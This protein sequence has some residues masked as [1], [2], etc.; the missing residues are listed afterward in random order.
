MRFAA[1]TENMRIHLNALKTKALKRLP[2]SEWQETGNL[3]Y[4]NLKPI[5]APFSGADPQG[6]DC[7]PD[8]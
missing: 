6:L 8:P 5:E 1:A 2:E 7:R 4:C 3:G